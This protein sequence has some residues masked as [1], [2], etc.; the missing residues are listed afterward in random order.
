MMKQMEDL[1]INSN[2]AISQDDIE[3]AENYNEES[4]LLVRPAPTHSVVEAQQCNN[5]FNN[6]N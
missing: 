1:V 6:S 2:G 3:D 5:A 4:R